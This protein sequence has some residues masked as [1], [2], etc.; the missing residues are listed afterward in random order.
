MLHQEILAQ[1]LHV[2]EQCRTADA[3]RH[4]LSGEL[5]SRRSGYFP[6]AIAKTSAGG[7]ARPVIEIEV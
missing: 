3:E 4:E 6:R 1:V 5:A 2:Q 7:F